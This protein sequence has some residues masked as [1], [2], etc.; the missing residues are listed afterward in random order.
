MKRLN[1]IFALGL[2]FFACTAC[3]KSD[4]LKAE[5]EVSLTQQESQT[6]VAL[7]D[8]NLLIEEA[9]AQS[10]T[11]LRATDTDSTMYLNECPTIT[12]NNETSPKVMT[13]DF[14]T[15]CTGKDGKIRSGKI[16]VTAE[17]FTAIPCIRSKS[18]E[19]FYVDGKKL[20]GSIIQTILRDTANNTRTAMMVED[21]TITF[22]NE[23]GTAKRVANLTRQD[24]RRV[25]GIRGN[26]QT[27]SWGTTEFTRISGV[28]LTKT[29][30]AEKPLIYKATCRQIVSGIV[31][32]TTSD[33]RNWM[34]D[35]GNGDCDNKATLTRNGKTKEIT[36][37]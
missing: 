30:T 5:D 18:F 34:L 6:E 27:V 35:Y 1:I 24:Q 25:L 17:S 28:K 32:F 19:N 9:I 12:T 33:N 11:Q 8:V 37:R 14:G 21:I 4:V 10:L 23:E 36:L 31:T 16:I 26:N 13:I 20:E 7:S 15:T 22:P 29:I 2:S 3:Q